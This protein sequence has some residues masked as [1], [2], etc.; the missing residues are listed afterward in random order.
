MCFAVIYLLKHIKVQSACPIYICSDGLRRP[1]KY[2]EAAFI[3]GAVSFGGA[4]NPCCRTNISQLIV[5]VTGGNHQ[6]VCQML[7]AL[8][9]IHDAAGYRRGIFEVAEVRNGHAARS[10]G[11]NNFCVFRGR[12]NQGERKC[13]WRREGNSWYNKIYRRC[14]GYSDAVAG[15]RVGD[16][17]CGRVLNRKGDYAAGGG[18]STGSRDR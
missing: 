14:L 7:T 17:L 13:T 11:S 16:G 1:G 5:D 2:G 6:W 3:R 15:G 18:R 9:Q 8:R 12:I 10:S 4:G